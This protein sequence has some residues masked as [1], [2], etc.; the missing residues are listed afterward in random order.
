M[1]KH[2]VNE[3]TRLLINSTLDLTRTQKFPNLVSGEPWYR[4][5]AGDR[6]ASNLE[7]SLLKNLSGVSLDRNF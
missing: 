3:L 6:A 5:P 4:V 7:R 2:C 1:V